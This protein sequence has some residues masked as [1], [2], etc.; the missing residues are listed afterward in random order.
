MV[1]NFKIAN[2]IFGG[3]RFFSQYPA[4][5]YRLDRGSVSASGERSL[6]IAGPSSVDFTTYFNSLSLMK[7]KTYSAAL[8]FGLH[9]EYRGAS[10]R[11]EQRTAG[12]FDWE[13]VA[14]DGSAV[15]LVSSTE[16]T[17]FDAELSYDMGQVLHGFALESEGEYELRDAYYYAVVDDNDVREVELAVATTTFKKESYVLKNVEL[18]KKG[19]LESNEPIAK[20]FTLHI[21]DNGRTLSADDL[22]AARVTVHPNPNVGGSGGFARGMIEAMEQTPKATHVLLMDDDVEV[23]PES[24]IRVFNILSLV[25]DDYVDA[26]VSGAMM[27]LEEPDVRTEDLGY[28]SFGGFFAPLKPVGHMSVLHDVVETE[29]YRTPVDLYPDT[30]QQYAGWWFCAIPISMVEKHGL[31][32][33]LFV[34]SDDAEYSLRCNAD[35][36]TMNGICVWHNAFQYKYNPAVERYQVSRNTLVSQAV[37]GIAPTSD[38]MRQIHHMVQLDLKKY[39]YDD[40][41]LA[42][43][44]LE[45]FL[46][47]PDFIAH[48]IAEA[49]FMEANREK[50]TLTPFEELEKIALEQYGIDLSCLTYNNLVQEGIRSRSQ[51]MK[52]YL[53]FNGHRSSGGRRKGIAVIDAADSGYPAGKLFGVD[54][55][56]AVDMY[57]KRGAIRHLDKQR[58]KDIWCRYK[59]AVKDYDKRRDSLYSEY[60]KRRDEFTSIE[61]W[62]RYLTEASKNNS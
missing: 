53:S 8:R 48:P 34:R 2:L 56:I 10:V 32:L 42:V 5:L 15:N 33:P 62:K 44:G 43:K 57:S 13:S 27:S 45:D 1:V 18:I 14:V 49:R 6:R 29:T 59:A 52:D 54:T 22:N 11:F 24:F 16:W 40:A 28:F 39:D 7:W 3:S 36:M 26:F 46:L 37:T 31:P 51:R 21:I 20:H 41:E 9:F 47:G 60:A 25:K 12:N 4:M 19:V 61:F 50:E 30:K 23:L 17:Q 38:F 35:F 55:V 58:F